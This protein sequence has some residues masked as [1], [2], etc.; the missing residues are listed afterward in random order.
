VSGLAFSA[1]PQLPTNGKSRWIAFA[2]QPLNDLPGAS[3][4]LISKEW[5]KKNI[6]IGPLGT[7]Y[8]DIVYA[9]EGDT[10]SYLGL[11][12]VSSDDQTHHHHWGARAR[13][14]T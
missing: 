8:P 14:I 6:Q 2:A 9:M 11:I 7:E 1:A 3:A 12:P 4:D 10:P 5:L 13:L